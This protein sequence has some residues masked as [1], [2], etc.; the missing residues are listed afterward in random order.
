[1]LQVKIF[2]GLEYH[3]DDLANEVNTWIR[4]NKIDV[5]DIRVQISPQSSGGSITRSE[6]DESDILCYV[7]YR[8][9][10]GAAA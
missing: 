2:K 6:S 8:G 9:E 10:A 5:V 4:K 3:Y 1:M 7:I